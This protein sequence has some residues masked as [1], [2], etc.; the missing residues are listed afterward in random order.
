[1]LNG[2]NGPVGNFSLI[3]VAELQFA[4]IA[5]LIELLRAGR[6]REV[7]ASVAATEQF[8]AERVVAA[9]KTVWMTGCRSWY[10]DDRGIPAAW[11]W[12]FDRFRAE[13]TAPRLEAYDLVRR[14]VPAHAAVRPD[15]MRERPSPKLARLGSDGYGRRMLRLT[16]MV[17]VLMTMVTFEIALA[18]AAENPPD[19]YLC[20]AAGSTKNKRLPHQRARGSSCRIVSAGCSVS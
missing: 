17:A 7:S 13:M 16:R 19:D 10:L 9:R 8:E 3:E 14:S 18:G 11:P 12:T 15:G 6:C 2:P 20:Y 4:Y 5:R 1:M